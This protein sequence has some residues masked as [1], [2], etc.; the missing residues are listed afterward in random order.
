MAKAIKHFFDSIR[1]YFKDK[2]IMKERLPVGLI[3]LIGRQGAGKTQAMVSMMSN[4]Y[5]Y[6]GKERLS[7]LNAY[8]FECNRNGFELTSPPNGS[9]YFSSNQNPFL[10]GNKNKVKTWSCDPYKVAIPNLDFE[11]QYFPRYSVIGLPEFD[12]VAG[13]RDWDS[14]SPFLVALAKYARHWDLTIIIDLQV[15]L[16]MDVALR[17]LMMYTVFIYERYETK[18]FWFKSKIVWNWLWVDNQLN[19]FAKDLTSML[20]ENKTAKKFLRQ[21][22]QDGRYVF[23]NKFHVYNR[24]NSKA[25]E[26]FFLYKIKDFDYIEHKPIELTPD[27]VN[28]YVESSPLVRPEEVKKRRSK[29][30][31]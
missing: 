19:S 21:S 13:C 20:A 12:I 7:E 14:L 29:E 5:E 22:V 23:K 16:Q 2:R 8:I 1:F 24:Y 26:V 11:V 4:D 9:L 28:A 31:A 15:F 18:K 25:G 17:R 10:L 30:S 27:G 3:C 6:H